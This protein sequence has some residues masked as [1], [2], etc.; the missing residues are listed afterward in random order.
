ML[1]LHQL[2]TCLADIHA[3]GVGHHIGTKT[4]GS[5]FCEDIEPLLPQAL[6][7]N[8]VIADY[9]LFRYTT[10]TPYREPLGGI[11]SSICYLAE[12]LSRNGHEVCI[13]NAIE[14]PVESLGVRCLPRGDV[15]AGLLQSAD[16]VIVTNYATGGS[17]VRPHV[18]ES[19]PIILWTGHAHDEQAMAPL[20]FPEL[21]DAYD[22]IVLVSKWQ[23]EMF[24]KTFELPS[25]RCHVIPYGFAPAFENLFPGDRSIVSHKPSPPV[26]A[27]TSTPFR[28]LKLLLA[29]FPYIRAA[30]PGTRLK[31]FSSM[32]VYQIDAEADES[33]F[34][35]LY[36]RCEDIEGV[37]YVG[38]LPQPQLAQELR[39]VTA[40]AYPNTFPET[41]C[42]SVTEAMASG[43]LVISS[44]LG[45]LPQTGAGFARLIPLNGDWSQYAKRF[46]SEIAYALQSHSSNEPND[47]EKLLKQQVSYVHQH[48][49][50]STQATKW[51]ALLTEFSGLSK[52][53][54]AQEA[55]PH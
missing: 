3:G 40:L 6:S 37:E 16:A 24:C 34:G 14:S 9:G 35:E 17:L 54:L 8:I 28:G 23:Q 1:A 11:E 38:S 49:T 50:W 42:I 45:A 4:Q 12:E 19:T 5:T 47:V 44:E 7:M 25:N 46:V 41:Y 51:L 36:R 15:P 18:G 55:V 13:L 53:R 52:R 30:V 2:S 10:E 22:R 26:L 43:C 32:R 33:E 39:S 31:I 29:V 21:R 27:Y 20:H 48:R